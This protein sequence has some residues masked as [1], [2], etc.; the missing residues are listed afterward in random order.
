[1]KSLGAAE[2]RERDNTSYS[3]RRVAELRKEAERG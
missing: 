3:D 1:M 2:E